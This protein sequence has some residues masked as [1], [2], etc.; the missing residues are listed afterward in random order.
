LCSNLSTSRLSEA[1][2]LPEQRNWHSVQ[3]RL[4]GFRHLQSGELLDLQQ[5]ETQWKDLSV[6]AF[7]GLGNPEKL[8]RALRASG[9][10]LQNTVSLPDHYRYPDDFCAQF[11]QQ[12]LITSGKDAVK[13]DTSNPKV[14]VAEITVELPPALKQALE[15][16]IGSTID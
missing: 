2:R 8:F 7:T 4:C 12:V 14:W 16:C 10:D 1:L 13:L 5:A 15:D 3:V 11:N 9:I 6:L